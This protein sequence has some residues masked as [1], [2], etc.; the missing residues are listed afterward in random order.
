[1]ESSEASLFA[2]RVHL[3]CCTE[4]RLFVACFICTW[5]ANLPFLFVCVIF[6]AKHLTLSMPG[7]GGGGGGNSPK[8]FPP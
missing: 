7:G 1:M 3:K 2:A 5:L 6:C 8:V 4:V